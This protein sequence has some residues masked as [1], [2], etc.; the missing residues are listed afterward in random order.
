MPLLAMRRR[1]RRASLWAD[2]RSVGAELPRVSEGKLIEESEGVGQMA[3]KVVF[4]PFF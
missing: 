1:R 3:E 4:Y 2:G